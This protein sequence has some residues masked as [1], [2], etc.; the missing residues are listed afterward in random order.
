MAAIANWLWSR[1][2]EFKSWCHLRPA[3][4]WEQM[5]V[6]SIELKVIPLVWCG[7]VRK[8]VSCSG[9]KVLGKDVIDKTAPDPLAYF[10]VL[11]RDTNY[12]KKVDAKFLPQRAELCRCEICKE[13]SFAESIQAKRTLKGSFSC[14]IIIRRK[15]LSIFCIMKI[16]RLGPGSNPQPWQPIRRLSLRRTPNNFQ[17]PR[18]RHWPAA[19]RAVAMN[20]NSSMKIQLYA[21]SSSRLS[22][23]V[24]R[25]SR[26]PDARRTFR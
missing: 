20:Y 19:A 25:V 4:Q 10:P 26:N 12:R 11:V 9:A 17:K 23:T 13:F 7:D 22:D 21:I 24:L 5:H 15:P 16:H 1:I 18:P 2:R 6:K 8:R 3:V 14:R